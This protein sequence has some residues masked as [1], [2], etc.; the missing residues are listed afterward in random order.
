MATNGENITIDA[1]GAITGA[2]TG[3]TNTVS[4][5]TLTN[6]G[7]ISG[8]STGVHNQ[9]TIG[10]LINTGSISGGTTGLNNGGSIGTLSNSGTISGS[11]SASAW[12]LQLPERRQRKVAAIALVP[13]G[14]P[15]TTKYKLEPV[16]F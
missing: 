10:A 14:V 9:G 6:S 3:V 16:D 7:R 5:G 12:L 15:S 13:F 11:K 8:N 4:I 1:G 2:T